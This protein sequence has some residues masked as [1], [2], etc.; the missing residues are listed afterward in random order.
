MIKKNGF[1]VLL[2]LIA[3][4]IMVVSGCTHDPVLPDIYQSDIPIFMGNCN[5]DTLYYVLD[6]APILVSNCAVSNC[7]DATT[8]EKGIDLSTYSQVMK[9]GGVRPFNG[10]ASKIIKAMR[11]KG[12]ERMPPSPANAL[13]SDAIALVEKWIDQGAYNFECE[14]TNAVCDSVNFNFEANVKPI[15]SKYCVGCHSGNNPGGDI[16]LT[17]YGEIKALVD[18]GTLMGVI[19]RK[20]GFKEM[21]KGGSRLRS[22]YINTLNEWIAT[23]APNN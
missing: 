9:T 13:S 6:V 15:L 7:H 5:S 2:G 4:L 20:D 16:Y 19:E 23:G 14:D 21:P 3:P 11:K 8:K 18:D 1:T 12:E 22:C 17:N 10:T